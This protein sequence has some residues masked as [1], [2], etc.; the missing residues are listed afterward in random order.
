MRLVTFNPKTGEFVAEVV[1]DRDSPRR[2]T[3]TRLSGSKRQEMIK[4]RQFWF[5]LHVTCDK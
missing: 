5:A 2:W 3:S 1:H 4:R